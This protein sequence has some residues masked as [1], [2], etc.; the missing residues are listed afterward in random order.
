MQLK[1]EKERVQRE[2]EERRNRIELEQF[3]RK[4]DKRRNK[5]RRRP[6]ETPAPPSRPIQFYVLVVAVP[7]LLVAIIMAFMWPRV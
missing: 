5:D 4:F 1:E 3:Q 2:E 6:E 7:L